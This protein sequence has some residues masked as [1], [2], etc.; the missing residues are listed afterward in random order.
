MTESDS[1]HHDKVCDECYKYCNKQERVRGECDVCGSGVSQCHGSAR[2]SVS[3][4][5][6]DIEFNHV[7]SHFL[8]LL[9]VA[10]SKMYF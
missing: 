3:Q 2:E 7:L 10:I 8:V 1:A 4:Y 6:S 9:L 5:P